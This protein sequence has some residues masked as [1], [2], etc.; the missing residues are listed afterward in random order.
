MKGE[1]NRRFDL[2]HSLSQWE[3]LFQ[4]YFKSYTVEK[5]ILQGKNS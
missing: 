3:I 4:I 1:F 5:E 2:E